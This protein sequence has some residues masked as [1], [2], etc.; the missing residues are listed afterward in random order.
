MISP[1]V[2]TAIRLRFT[3]TSRS[4][5]LKRSQVFLEKYLELGRGLSPDAGQR[6]VEVPPM[7]GVDE[8]MRRW[9]FFMILEHNTIVN[10]SITATVSQLARGEPL[11]GAATI[12][13]KTEVMPSSSADDTQLEPFCNSVVQHQRVVAELRRIRGTKTSPHP[14]FGEFDAHKWNCMFAF[15]LGLHYPQATYVVR[16][17][18]A[19]RDS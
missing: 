1:F 12:D 8:N 10:R 9:S 11:S 15:H 13:P 5:A 16:V 18:K 19:E 14:V 4:S 3:C 7:R 2:K 6:S 17:A